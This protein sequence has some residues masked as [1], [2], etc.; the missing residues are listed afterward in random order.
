MSK[1]GSIGHPVLSPHA[2]LRWDKV[3]EQHQIVY[4]EGIFVL[5]ATSAA[6]V[7]LCDGRTIGEL[8]AE[9]RKDFSGEAIEAD[10]QEFLQGLFEKGLIRD[11]RGD[12]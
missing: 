11:D 6:I 5:N 7:K 1:A 3:R 8:I 2:R 12:S 10:V 4:P 9:L